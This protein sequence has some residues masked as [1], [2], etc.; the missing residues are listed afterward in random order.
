MATLLGGLSAARFLKD[1][2]HKKPLLV[3]QAIPRF[4][5]LISPQEMRAL[6][7]QEDVESRLVRLSQGK[8]HLEHGPFP[9]SRFGKLPKHNWTLL[10]Q[11]LDH[12]LPSAAALL[13]QF[14]FIP[15]ARLDDLMVSYAQLG[16]GVGPH[17]DSYDV[18]L[19]QGLGHRRWR[20]SAQRNLDLIEDLPLKILKQFKPTEEYLLGPGDMLYLPPQ[21]AHDGVAED[22][23][24]TYSIGFRAPSTLDIAQAFLDFLRDRIDLPGRYADPLLT[25]Q[26]HAGE[27]P[28]AMVA[29]LEAMIAQ[30]RWNNRDI[31]EFAGEYLTEPKTHV[32]FVPPDAP[33]APNAFAKAAAKQGIALHG[34]TRLLFTGKRFFINGEMLLAS[35]PEGKALKTLADTRRLPPWPHLPGELLSVFQDW[36]EAGW[37]VLAS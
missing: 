26:K 23:C 15:H 27:I 24:M 30:I 29:Q 1:Y 19:L 33:L 10:V 4:H 28:P 9:E 3:R 25:L 37:L 31:A 20:I 12:H 11:S 34:K 14:N 21:Y 32:Y 17:F 22:D 2:W 5:G 8:W 6:A 18:F 7:R 35:G 16:G 13:E 36:Y